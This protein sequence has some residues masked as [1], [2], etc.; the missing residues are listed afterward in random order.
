MLKYAWQSGPK[1]S[2]RWLWHL[3]NQIWK[4]S[5]SSKIRNIGIL[6]HIDA[7]KTTTTERMLFYAGKTRALGEVH[8][9]NTVT[10]Y[11]T[12]ERE[13]GITICSS[14]VT[15]SWNDHRINL[16][17]TPGHIDFTMEVEQSL[18]A[19]D[20]VVVVLDG[21]AGVEA[22]T[23]TVWSQADKHKLPRLIFVNKMDR[24]DADF[25]KCVSD[26]KDKLETQPVC[27]QY[28]VKNEDGVLAIN[29][30]ITLERLSWQQ[31]D[32]GRSYRNVKLEPSDDLR[33]LQEKRN[34]LIDQLSGLDDELADVVISTES[35]DNVDNALIERALRRAT[36]QQKVVP[37]LLGS[38]YKNVGIQRLMDAVNAYLP[39]PEERNQIYDCFGT[40]VAGK[41]FK[42]VHD[43][44]RG[45][46]TLVRILR[47]EIKRGMRLI[48]ARGQAEVVSKLYEPLADEYREVSAVQ[49]G[50]VV[51][52]AGLKSTVTGDL[53][54]SS[55]SALKNAQKRYKQSL[56]NTAAKVEE[57]DELD[58]SDELFAID[59]QIPDA[60]YFCSIE[61]P[62]V[63]SQTAMEQALK[64]L[65]REDPSLR[66]SY[67]SVTGQTVLGGMGELHM[68]IIKSRI[69]S[70][71]KI[72]V[73]LGPLQIAYKE[74]IEAPAL[75]TLSVEKEIAGSKQSVSITLEVVKNQA[76]LFSLD[77][78][79]DN[80]PNL[81]TLRPRI[82]QVLRKGSISALERGPR[83]GGQVVETQIRLHNATIG[84]GTADSFVMA[85]AAQCVQKLL[86]TSGTRLLEPI[87][88]LQ[89]VAPSE[90]ISGIMADLSRRR[91]LINDVLPKGERNKMILV[92]A[93][94]AELSGYSSALRTISSGTASMTMQPCGFSSMNSVDESLAERRAQ[95]LE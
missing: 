5:Y 75:T 16:L 84:R 43:K 56:G 89:I 4:R 58:E 44:Q 14:A 52:C 80:L 38:A 35:F 67:D 37:V 18:Y 54:T 22:Q 81:N 65:Q 8:R 72:D 15:F 49:S 41:V 11:L 76:E 66:V 55:Q 9:G 94:L 34:E 59:P 85:T 19:V 70:E 1:Q 87:M 42:I 26:L 6:A 92:N 48:S 68:D 62:S 71:Y 39:A 61:P 29:D 3:S 20:G 60:V 7:G 74:T 51:I 95:G 27:L 57:D 30:V 33:L 83:V 77:K 12:Q 93:P 28:P 23:V 91:A 32:L 21:T 73:D 31:K 53:L 36:T 24:P 2:N 64:Q 46:L 78:S 79:P 86:S 69:L 63:S 90:R 82:L 88:A 13:R 50:D 10:D 47:G 25:E 40:E 17:D 45:P